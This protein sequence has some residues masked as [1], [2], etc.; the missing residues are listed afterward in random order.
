MSSPKLTKSIVEKKRVI[1]THTYIHIK[2]LHTHVQKSLV[3]IDGL[4]SLPPR[5]KYF[6]REMICLQHFYNK[7]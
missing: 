1:Y 5:T 4:M 7:S 2:Q 6:Q 3:K